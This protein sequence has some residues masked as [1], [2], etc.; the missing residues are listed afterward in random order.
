[1]LCALRNCDLFDVISEAPFDGTHSAPE[2]CYS[3]CY[4]PKS[5]RHPQGINQDDPIR[6][7]RAPAPIKQPFARTGSCHSSQRGGACVYLSCILSLNS[8]ANTD[9]PDCETM[10]WEGGNIYGRQA[11]NFTCE[12]SKLVST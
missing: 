12:W 9:A 6:Q 5:S 7:V 2:M 10:S 8:M 3:C 4:G 11:H 1:M